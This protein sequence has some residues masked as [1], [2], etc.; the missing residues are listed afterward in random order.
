MGGKLSLS[1]LERADF[2]P[3]SVRQAEQV[4]E[5]EG[6]TEPQLHGTACHAATQLM[7]KNNTP[8]LTELELAEVGKIYPLTFEDLQDC[9]DAYF[10]FMQKKPHPP[11]G[12][13]CKLLIEHELE[14]GLLGLES[15][16]RADGQRSNRL[17]LAWVVPG[18][19]AI[20]FELKFGFT[21]VTHPKRNLQVQGQGVA[22]AREFNLWAVGLYVYQPKAWHG[23]K[24]RDFQMDEDALEFAQASIAMKVQRTKSPDAPL[25]QGEFC[26]WCPAKAVCPARMNKPMI[27]LPNEMSLEAYVGMRSPVERAQLYEQLLSFSEWADDCR[28]KMEE[29]APKLKIEGYGLRPGDSK[30]KWLKGDKVHA[31]IKKAAKLAGIKPEKMLQPEAIGTVEKLL[32][33]KPDA[34]ALLDPFVE[35]PEVKESFGKLEAA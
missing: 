21:E 5:Q 15:Y 3:G 17:D 29:L 34:L 23:E 26:K 22:L 35:R 27:P 16:V 2:C 4:P 24:L 28:E 10:E 7:V 9:S 32:K 19:V 20:I 25:R 14:V 6:S 30:R 31:A 13:E 12:M 18:H 1:S 8:E 33:G 11:T